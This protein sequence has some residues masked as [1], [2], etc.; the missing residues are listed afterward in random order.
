MEISIVT[1][2]IN[3]AYI[4]LLD[5]SNIDTKILYNTI[6]TTYELAD[7]CS[8]TLLTGILCKYPYPIPHPKLLNKYKI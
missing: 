7:F 5:L 4:F 1:N 6:F 8:G 2:T 3:H